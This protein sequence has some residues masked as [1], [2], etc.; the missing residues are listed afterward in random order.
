MTIMN[1]FVLRRWRVG[2]AGVVAPRNTRNQFS[3]PSK[4]RIDIFDHY[5]TQLRSNNVVASP[6]HATKRVSHAYAAA[7]RDP[8]RHRQTKMLL[9]NCAACAAPLAHDAP[10][11]VRCRTRYCNATC[12]VNC[13][14]NSTTPSYCM[15]SDGALGRGAQVS[16]NSVCPPPRVMSLVKL[17]WHLRISRSA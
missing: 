17:Q 5:R 3:P 15:R 11:C 13:A 14:R 2:G 9:I 8:H 16:Q 7:A 4:Y 12:H 6:P 1:L 10:R